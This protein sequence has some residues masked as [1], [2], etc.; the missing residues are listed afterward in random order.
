M[1][2]RSKVAPWVVILAALLFAIFLEPLPPLLE[3]ARSD[4][5]TRLAEWLVLSL[6]GLILLSLMGVSDTELDLSMSGFRIRP[7]SAQDKQ[8]GE[9]PA[10]VAEELVRQLAETRQDNLVL[11][12]RAEAQIEREERMLAPG[13]PSDQAT[14]EDDDA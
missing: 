7:A 3:L 2:A 6:L 1:S 14:L 8:S 13:T 4:V 5:W 11:Q 9:I 12:R 10:A